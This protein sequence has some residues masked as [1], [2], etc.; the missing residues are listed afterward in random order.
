[1][2]SNIDKMVYKNKHNELDITKAKSENFSI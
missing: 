1:M 2:W